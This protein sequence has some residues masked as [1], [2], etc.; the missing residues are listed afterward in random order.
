MAGRPDEMLVAFDFDG[1]LAESDP[2][3]RLAEQHGTDG[4]VAG[5]LDRMASG[6]LAFE[7]G[8]RSVAD[9][10]E[11]LPDAEVE[12]ALDHL[13]PRPAAVDLL[14]A[15]HRNDHHVAIVTDA[16][17]RAVEACLAPDAFDAD[18][19][20]AN[21]LPVE[22][23]ALTGDIEG[24]PVGHG[25]DDPLERLVVEQGRDWDEVVAVG[26]TRRDLPMLQAA[27][28]GVGLDPTPVVDSNCDRA[29]PTMDRLEQVFAERNLC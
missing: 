10:L 4:E 15:L 7:T 1:A 16:P 19:V 11:G 2:Y 29:V 25:K 9:H 5:V 28:F 18:T 8:L 14:A 17:E 3:R 26:D 13:R 27:G 12:T 24:P 21:R 22:N 6:D 23:G 20:V